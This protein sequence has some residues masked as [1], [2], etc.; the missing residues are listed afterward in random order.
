[1]RILK[2]VAIGVV[3]LVVGAGMAAS[4]MPGGLPTGGGDASCS[5]PVAWDEAATHDGQRV[6][7][8]GPVADATYEPDVEGEPTFVNVGN[9]YPDGDRFDVVIFP[10]VRAQRA[11]PPENELPGERVC[12][13]GEVDVRDGVPQIVLRDATDLAVTAE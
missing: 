1:M 10:D 12:V 8:T 11:A 5:D 9:T 3:V 13:I 6:A 4:R 7:V 2:G